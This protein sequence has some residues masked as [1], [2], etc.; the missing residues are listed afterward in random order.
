LRKQIGYQGKVHKGEATCRKI[1]KGEWKKSE[2]GEKRKL[3]S[4][5]EPDGGGEEWG[6]EEGNGGNSIQ[7]RKTS[8]VEERKGRCIEKNWEFEE[9]P[10]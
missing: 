8:G 4:W 9:R 10:R 3:R 2:S 1:P 7:R 6:E 5:D